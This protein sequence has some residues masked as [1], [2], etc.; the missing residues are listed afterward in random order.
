MK[1]TKTQQAHPL[2]AIEHEHQLIQAHMRDVARLLNEGADTESLDESLRRL[3]K[4]VRAHHNHEEK[5]DLYTLYPKYSE[6]VRGALK[7]LK[8][9]HP[10][11]VLKLVKFRKDLA[12]GKDLGDSFLTFV[13]EMKAHE[14]EE[15]VIIREYR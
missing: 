8:N 11:L 13:E 10:L 14:R 3:E 12:A 1:R 7:A 2:R 6:K 5:T 15:A 4:L 9:E